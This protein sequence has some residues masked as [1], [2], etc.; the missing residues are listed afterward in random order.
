MQHVFAKDVIAPPAVML[1][2]SPPEGLS[3]DDISIE[4]YFSKDWHNQEIE[5]VWRKTWQLACRVE[6]LPNVGDHLVYEIVHDSLIVVRTAANEIRAYI[7][8]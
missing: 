8:A 4:R 2:E 7:N 5:K 1:E 6:E 3:T